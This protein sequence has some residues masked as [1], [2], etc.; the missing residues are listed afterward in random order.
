MTAEPE[1]FGTEL[2]HGLYIRDIQDDT[3]R[4]K[5]TEEWKKNAQKNSE[6]K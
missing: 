3:L 5:L 6:D 1:T 2:A 4:N